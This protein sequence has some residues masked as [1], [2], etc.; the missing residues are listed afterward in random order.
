MII[1]AAMQCI[2]FFILHGGIQCI[3]IDMLESVILSQVPSYFVITSA[4]RATGSRAVSATN[5]ET[6]EG[7]YL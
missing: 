6:K 5:G 4:G 7:L 3:G 2:D 1:S